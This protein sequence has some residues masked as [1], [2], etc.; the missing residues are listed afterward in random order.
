GSETVAESGSVTR[1]PS[2]RASAALPRV[3]GLAHA[4]RL[5]AAQRWRA[6]E[7][8]YV[9]VLDSETQPGARAAAALAA[10]DLRLD[11]LGRPHAALA[12]FERAL[13][14]EPA[15]ALGEQARHGIARA[16]QALGDGPR[17]ATALRAFLRAHPR[18]R[19]RAV[20]EARLNALEH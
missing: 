14:F 20:A 17:E 6:A 19:M 13:A 12:L 18:S 9:A 11:Q 4:N 8:G 16:Y 5:R 2:A 7:A 10:A 15:S 3:D 1:P